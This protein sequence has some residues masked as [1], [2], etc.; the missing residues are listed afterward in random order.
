M[1]RTRDFTVD[2]VEPLPPVDGDPARYTLLTKETVL[3]TVFAQDP[4]VVDRAGPSARGRGAG[5]AAAAGPAGPPLP[6]R[7]RR[8]SAP[9]PPPPVGA[10]R[11]GR[12]GLPRPLGRRRR[13]RDARS[14]VEDRDFRAQNVFAVAAHTLALF[15]QHLGRPDPLAL[16]LPAALPRARRPGSRPTPS[17]PASTTPSCSAGSPRSA[18]RPPLYTALSYDVIAH[19]VSHAILDG[20]RPRYTEPG[21]PDQLAF[22]EALA[23][24]VALLS[25]FDLTGVAQHLLD[26]E[27]TGEVPVPSDARGPAHRR[28]D[29]QRG[30][31]PRRARRS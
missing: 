24:L 2:V 22:H 27:G 1:G 10:A 29:E 23:D 12:L 7:R 14:L 16:R 25:V 11:P 8:A 4:S 18:S 30:A 26:P 17:T 31:W 28:S 5:R 21:L 3:M 19:E 20:L 13:D 15:E 6:R 9:T